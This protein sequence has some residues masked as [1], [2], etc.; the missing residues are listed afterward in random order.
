MQF[1]NVNFCLCKANGKND[2]AVVFNR[3][4]TT[5]LLSFIESREIW[6]DL[7]AEW[8][9]GCTAYWIRNRM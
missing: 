5:M 1:F 3:I 8:M 4:E 6:L 9:T 2:F 7:I